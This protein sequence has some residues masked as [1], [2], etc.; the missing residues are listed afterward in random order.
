[1]NI[2]KI[3]KSSGKK[4]RGVIETAHGTVETPN[5]MVVATQGSVKAVSA[6]DLREWGS[7]FIIANTYHLYLRPGLEILNEAGGLH[8]FMNWDKTIFTDSGGFQV[9]SL[10]KLRKFK[11]DGIIF[12]SHIDGSYHTFTPENNVRM[13]RSIGGDVMMVLDECMEFPVTH[14]Y[15]KHSVERTV[16]WAER[17]RREFEESSP[18]YGYNQSQF[19]II[20]GST[21]H[22]LRKMCAEKLS[23][24]D[25]EGYAMGGVAIGE[26]K[27]YIRKV[28]DMADEI[29]PREKC[30]YLM[31]V[32][33]ED[34]VR[35]AVENGFDIF[36]CVIPTR[37][38]RNGAL[39][40]KNGRMLIKNA[41]FKKDFAPVEEGCDCHLCRNYSRSYL[42][43]LFKAGEMLGGILA[44]EHNVN[45]YLRLMKEIRDSI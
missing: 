15:A 9:F 44:T 34:D 5:L 26:S 4:R 32:G 10:S 2:F 21:F 3:K 13:Q 7:E 14:A 17:A 41:K 16:K 27:D 39:F 22:D 35:Y 23:E 29:M 38:A 33:E 42:H 18:L 37:N 11:D 45:Y 12:Q 20:Q 30:R 36:D 24:I 43:H 19:G 25:F 40:T 6:V 8:R 31:G 28:I 1:M